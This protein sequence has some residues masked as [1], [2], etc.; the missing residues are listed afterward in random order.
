[1]IREKDIAIYQDKHCYNCDRVNCCGYGFLCG[2]K[3][4]HWIPDEETEKE[5]KK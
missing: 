4:I 5:I 3:Y 1:M 2:D